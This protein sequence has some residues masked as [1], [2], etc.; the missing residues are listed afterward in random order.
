MYWLLVLFLLPITFAIISLISR[1]QTPPGIVDGQLAK[2]PTSPNCVCSERD[3]EKGYI[4][5]ITYTGDSDQAWSAFRQAIE[6]TGG[7]VEKDEDGYL[8]ASYRSLIFRFIDDVECR[9]DTDTNTIHIRSAARSGYS[10]F[11]VN[12]KRVEQIRSEYQQRIK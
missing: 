4:E 8:W 11:G 6:S 3:S 10:D 12:R 9:L 7:T 2:C 1:G 5:P